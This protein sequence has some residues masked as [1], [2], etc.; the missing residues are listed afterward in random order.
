MKTFA[1]VEVADESHIERIAARARQADREELMA[2]NAMTPTDAM[3]EGLRTATAARTGFVDGEPICMFGISPYWPKPGIGIP[4][5]IGTDLLERHWMLF[6]RRCRSEFE[7]VCG[8]YTYLVNWVDDR[9]VVA[10][11]WLQWL[12]FRLHD[13]V[14]YGVQGLPFR[15]FDKRRTIDV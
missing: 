13:A 2:S 15:M 10:H 11:R 14:P 6:A 9:N 4:W 12:G 3:F 5:M 8:G 7:E 1:H